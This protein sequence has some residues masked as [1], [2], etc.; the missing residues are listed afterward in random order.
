M[1]PASAA[2]DLHTYRQIQH[3][4]PAE[5][6]WWPRIRR[7]RH[8]G[9]LLAS[10]AVHVA[11]YDRL[12]LSKLRARSSFAA[13]G[14]F[15]SR[16]PAQRR[17]DGLGKTPLC[18]TRPHHP[19]RARDRGPHRGAPLRRLTGPP[20]GVSHGQVLTPLCPTPICGPTGRRNPTCAPGAAP[21]R[22]TRSRRSWPAQG[23]CRTRTRW[24]AL[25]DLY[26]RLRRAVSQ[27]AHL[28]TPAVAGNQH[29]SETTVHW[30]ER[31]APITQ[32]EV[33]P[34]ALTQ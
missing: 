11:P 25:C 30:N 5:P 14:L 8:G 6:A 20:G 16:C 2:A 4:V 34:S 10:G 29:R 7:P 9:T 18:R 31:L 27:A 13:A 3:Q 1:L 17:R 28:A 15:G 24:M 33:N 12:S 22:P 23:S 21:N 32:H 19:F 26:G